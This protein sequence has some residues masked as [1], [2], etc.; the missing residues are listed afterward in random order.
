MKYKVF[1]FCTKNKSFGAG[2][3][4]SG[5]NSFE[6]FVKKS[7]IFSSC[8][9]VGLENVVA[10]AIFSSTILLRRLGCRLMHMLQAFLARSLQSSVFRS[11]THKETA[12][13]L[14]KTV[15]LRGGLRMG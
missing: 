15:T 7:S 14:L 3:R 12:V 10:G 9:K 11:Q 5:T 13:T 1:P 6:T 2:S 8:K 4:S